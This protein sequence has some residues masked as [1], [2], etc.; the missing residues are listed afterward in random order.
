MRTTLLLAAA[1]LSA[2]CVTLPG[3]EAA[4]LEAAADPAALVEP[5]VQEL[6]GHATASPLARLAHIDPRTEALVAPVQREGFILD[7]QEVPQM[8]QIEIEWDGTARGSMAPMVNVP[9]SQDGQ[10][11]DYFGELSDS[12]LACMRL[13]V[14]ELKADRISIMAHSQMAVNI[15]F[16]LRVTTVGGAATLL[17]APHMEVERSDPVQGEALPCEPATDANA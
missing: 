6:T 2:G 16:V 11:V 9:T 15:D 10:V 8:L 4:T 13:P 17:D 7:I 14:E 12:G 1:L 5:V 3:Q